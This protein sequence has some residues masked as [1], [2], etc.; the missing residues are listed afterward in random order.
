M[1]TDYQL[2]VATAKTLTVANAFDLSTNVIDM[3]SKK[4]VGAGERLFMQFQV[5]TTFAIGAGTPLLQ[6]GIVMADSAD[7]VTN[8]IWDAR[9]GAPFIA[10]DF[11]AP[12]YSASGLTAGFFF[13]IPFAPISRAIAGDTGFTGGIANYMKRYIAAAWCQ[14]NFATASFST[15]AMSARMVLNPSQEHELQGI[16]PAAFKVL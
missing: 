11:T 10:A 12:R 1:Y 4:D 13:N 3:G 16:Y 6:F 2:E 9:T 14:P 5:T 7:F 15:G 8:A